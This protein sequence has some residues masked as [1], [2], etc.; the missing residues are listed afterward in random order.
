MT[1]PSLAG[2]WLQCCPRAPPG[3]LSQNRLR[4]LLSCATATP[5]RLSLICSLHLRPAHPRLSKIRSRP[6]A[7]ADRKHWQNRCHRTP[8]PAPRA[9]HLHPLPPRSPKACRFC[10]CSSAFSSASHALATPRPSSSH[11]S[12]FGAPLRRLAMVA[13]PQHS[14]PRCRVRQLP[15]DAPPRFRFL[16]LPGGGRGFVGSSRASATS[17]CPRTSCSPRFVARA[18]AAV[19]RGPSP[20]KNPPCYRCRRAH[21]TLDLTQLSRPAPRQP[22]SLPANPH[23]ATGDCRTPPPPLTPRQILF[24]CER[25][26]PTRLSSPAIHSQP[27]RARLDHRTLRDRPQE[28]M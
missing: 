28:A 11:H 27:Q 24:P 18:L 5:I 26:R 10:V 22:Y 8:L 16:H 3:A 6:G 19:L 12:K 17:P 20:N 25:R 13:P 15:Q 2:C 14:V 1:P 4:L 23:S 21:A 9:S 7:S